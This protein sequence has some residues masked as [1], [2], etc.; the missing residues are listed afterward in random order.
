[1][2]REDTLL[3]K[4]SDPSS[5]ARTRDQ[6]SPS[7]TPSSPVKDHDATLVASSGASGCAATARAAPCRLASSRRLRSCLR[8]ALH[9]ALGSELFSAPGRS[10]RASTR[11]TLLRHSVGGGGERNRTDDLL[12]AKQALSQLSYTPRTNEVSATRDSRALARR[13]R[14]APAPAQPCCAERRQRL[15][16]ATARAARFR[17]ERRQRRSVFLHRAA[18]A[19]ASLPLTR[20]PF[21]PKA[22]MV[23]QG[24]FEPPTSR[25][26]SA[27][28]NQLSY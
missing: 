16:Q 25:L 12:L 1:L 14:A 8:R 21:A 23:G 4:S 5:H 17:T 3:K 2:R 27:R 18:P 28:S 26:S 24:G 15:R 6:T 19:V 13:K 20:P 11:M 9:R 10:R 7:V 22:Q